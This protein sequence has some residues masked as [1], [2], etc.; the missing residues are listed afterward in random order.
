ML[1]QNLVRLGVVVMVGACSTTVFAADP[2]SAKPEEIQKITQ[3]MPDTAPA[4]PQKAR[5]VLVFTLTRGFAHSSVPVAAKALEI[6]GQKTGAFEATISDDPAMFEPEKLRAFDAVV[7]DNTTG[8]PF[9]PDTK[10]MTPE[11]KQTAKEQSLRLRRSLL[12][13]VSSGKGLVG[14]HAATDCFYDWK[15]Y[16]EMMG[17]YFNG[18]PFRRIVVKNDDPASPINA[19]FSGEGFTIEDEMYTFKAPYSRKALHVLLSI[20]MQKTQ[21]PDDP[22][23]PGFKKDE[24]RNDH[25]YAISWIHPYRQGRVFYCSFGHEHNIFW[26]TP[27]LKHYLAGVQY[28]LGDL[29]A[30]ATP[31]SNEGK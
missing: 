13:F 21:L 20:D 26:K 2:P 27:I 31:S 12:E 3:A 28:A 7:M 11:Q 8:D 30:E 19:V 22:A 10:N 4:K 29:A 18:H 24:N 25:D 5:K 1:S 14:I 17:G 15:E 6:M 23:R 9:A 16:G